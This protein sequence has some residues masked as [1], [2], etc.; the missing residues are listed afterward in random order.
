M[1]ADYA[2]L[3]GAAAAQRLPA[4]IVSAEW[5]ERHLLTPGRLV[6][7]GAL[8]DLDDVEVRGRLKREHAALLAEH[9]MQQ[10]DIAEVRSRTRVVTQ[11][12]SRALFE[13]GA[14]AIR[15]RSNLDDLTCLALFEGRAELEPA[16]AALEL[17]GDN[18]LLV[19]VC[20][21]FGLRVG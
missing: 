1:L 20:E 17:T 21:E 13:S 4:G 16:G 3:F 9:G 7:A 19:Q 2:E 15:F 11:T 10:L 18:E 8:I 12:I 14:A 5:R 6:L